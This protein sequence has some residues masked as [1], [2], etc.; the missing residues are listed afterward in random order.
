MTWY[1]QKIVEV[2]LSKHS[3]ILGVVQNYAVAMEGLGGGN[4]NT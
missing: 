1:S 3:K 4:S 2:K